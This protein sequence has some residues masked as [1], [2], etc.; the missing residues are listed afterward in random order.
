[1]VPGIACGGDLKGIWRE[2]DDDTGNLAALIRIEKLP[3]GSYEGSI[4]KTFPLGGADDGSVCEH[5]SGSLHNHPLRG[6]RILS[7]M[8]RKSD[9][10]FDGGEVLDPDDGKIY[11]CRVRLSDD[12]NTIEVTGYLGINWIGQSEIWRRAK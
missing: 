2:Y 11:R 10:I 4:E 9:L 5:C 12:G 7:G 1:M 6:L 8:K 3:D